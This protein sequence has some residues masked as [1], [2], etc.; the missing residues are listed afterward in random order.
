VSLWAIFISAYII[1]FSGALAPGPLLSVTVN[2]SFQRGIKAGPQL[3]TGHAILEAVTVLAVAGGLTLLVQNGIVYG[4]IAFV[5][6]TFIAWMGWQ[7]AKG[8]IT[9][10]IHLELEAKTEKNKYGP[11]LVGAMTSLANPYFVL[12]WLTVGAGYVVMALRFGFPGLLAFYFGHI[13]ADYT[14]YTAVSAAVAG[15][16]RY[17]N[18]AIYRGVV[19][20]CGLFMLGMAAWF[21][22]S[23]L[24]F[25]QGI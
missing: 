16:R 24:L 13:L 5:G 18:Q 20:C 25:L 6:G 14:W 12:W 23:G 19:F 4:V 7:F 10:T 8:A 9:K 22:R 21:V 2:D 11:L 1:G 3:I 15:G 17:I